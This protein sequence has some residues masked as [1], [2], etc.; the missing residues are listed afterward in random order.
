MN[1]KILLGTCCV[2]IVTILLVVYF[3][4]NNGTRFVE[5][6]N[7]DTKYV[8]DNTEK[9][10]IPTMKTDTKKWFTHTNCSKLKILKHRSISKHDIVASAEITDS[11]LVKSIMD[12]IEKLSVEGDR[13]ISFGED[14]EHI[15][16]IFSCEKGEQ[17]VEI[18]NRGFKT[19][20]TTFNAIGDQFEKDLYQEVVG[21][22][23]DDKK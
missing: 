5:N 9:I 2:I 12:K 15:D 16:M 14:A 20:A 11:K 1:R 21:Y 10:M 8:L 13:Y 19:P 3:W 6:K 7:Y 18:Y 17:L 4:Y 23:H 22:L